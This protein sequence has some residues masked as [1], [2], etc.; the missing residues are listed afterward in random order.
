MLRCIF[1]TLKDANQ[2]VGI[3]KHESIEWVAYESVQQKCINYETVH[4][5]PFVPVFIVPVIGYQK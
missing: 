5:I 4:F 3:D 1:P 2:L